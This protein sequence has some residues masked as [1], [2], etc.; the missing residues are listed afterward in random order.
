MLLSW[1]R[2]RKAFS[3]NALLVRSAKTSFSPASIIAL[4]TIK[5]ALCSIGSNVL[6]IPDSRAAS[7]CSKC[8]CL[9]QS[10]IE[11][12]A[13]KSDQEAA[14]LKTVNQIADEEKIKA[15]NLKE[16][17]MKER[18]FINE[19]T[20]VQ[21]LLLKGNSKLN[22]ALKKKD[23][24]QVVVAQAMLSSASSKTQSYR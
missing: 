20:A 7:S 5:D 6:R 23:N 19:L 14:K 15:E 2:C 3:I 4:R 9:L 21:E 13:I 8:S 16:L 18:I 22:N 12:E 10:W 24:A 11:E 17:R 1:C